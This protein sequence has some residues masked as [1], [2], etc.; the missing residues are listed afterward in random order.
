MNRPDLEFLPTMAGILSRLQQG[1]AE[2]GHA[3]LAAFLDMARDEAE[4]LIAHERELAKLQEKLAE[5]DS[6]QTWR[7]GEFPSLPEDFDAGAEEAAA[8]A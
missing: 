3:M 8:A 1:S 4:H 6:R 7:A 5:A 2:R